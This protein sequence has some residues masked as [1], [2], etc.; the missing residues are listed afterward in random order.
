M[1]DMSNDNRESGT[2]VSSFEVVVSNKLCLVNDS[3]TSIFITAFRVLQN[4]LLK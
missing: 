2:C 3:L 1:I 4:L